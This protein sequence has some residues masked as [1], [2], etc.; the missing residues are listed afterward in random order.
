VNQHLQFG[1]VAKAHGLKGELLVKTFDP[2]SNVLDEIER[3]WARL[4]SG[5]E[6]ELDIE[7]YREGPSGGLL[8]SLVGVETR[9]AAE[10]LC[11]SLLSAFREDLEAPD[12]GEYF[13]GDLIGLTAQTADGRLLG[14]VVD[15]WSS[16]PVPNLVIG[17]GADE[18]MVPFAAEFVTKID[19]EA[20]RIIIVPPEMDSP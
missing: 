3:V 9:E 10:A 13:Q 4:K 19:V 16:G 7:S 12:A 6:R 8:V 15:V 2:A 5:E 1:Y 20:R 18:L 11:G 17:E 14:T